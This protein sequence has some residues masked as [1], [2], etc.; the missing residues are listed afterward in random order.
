LAQAQR[1]RRPARH[2]E[3][4]VT[5]ELNPASPE[6]TDL[7][8]ASLERAVG[9]GY[10]LEH[11]TPREISQDL[12]D[13]DVD[14]EGIET[15]R[16]VPAITEWFRRRGVEPPAIDDGKIL[17]NHDHYDYPEEPNMITRPPR[18]RVRIPLIIAGA[19]I[20]AATII[21][22]AAII[23]SAADDRDLEPPA[24]Y[25]YD[26]GDKT[27]RMHMWCTSVGGNGL[28][29]AGDTNTFVVVQNDVECAE[30]G[31]LIGGGGG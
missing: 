26:A 11:F 14:F 25:T 24:Y 22:C 10:M 28:Y 23:A 3:D 9:N 31:A 6:F 29:Q 2:K 21:A 15:S 18:N 30:G 27:P 16:L 13:Y 5:T 19:V 17:E 8:Y 1:S 12:A 20:G 7:V 4:E